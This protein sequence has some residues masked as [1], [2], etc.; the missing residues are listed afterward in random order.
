MP[1]SRVGDPVTQCEVPVTLGRTRFR[2]VFD[3]ALSVNDGNS[4]LFGAQILSAGQLESS[5]RAG[6]GGVSVRS[7]WSYRS[8]FSSTLSGR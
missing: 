1:K 5:Q 8:S 2:G 4:L 6:S 3:Y 7:G